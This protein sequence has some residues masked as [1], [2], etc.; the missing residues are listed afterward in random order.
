MGRRG[1]KGRPSADD[2]ASLDSDPGCGRSLLCRLCGSADHRICILHG[3]DLETGKTAGEAVSFVW[4][5]GASAIFL[6]SVEQCP[7]GAGLEWLWGGPRVAVPE[8]VPD[9]GLFYPVCVKIPGI[10]GD[11]TGAGQIHV[12]Y[13]SAIS[14]GRYLCGG[15]VSSGAVP[16]VFQE[17]V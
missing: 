16:A 8:P 13:E 15:G 5:V 4:T 6:L 7:G 3:G 12:E 11:R 9:S 1:T 2:P 10:S 14:G 17:A